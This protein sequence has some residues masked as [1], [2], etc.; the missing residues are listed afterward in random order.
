MSSLGLSLPDAILATMVSISADAVIAVDEELRIV[1]F[2]SGAERIFGWSSAEAT[3]MELA[4][5][6]PHRFRAMHSGHVTLFGTSHERARRM[7]ERQEISGLRRNGEEFAAE[8]SIARLASEGRTVYTAVLRDVSERKRIER[9][10]RA[11]LRARDDI[12]GIVSHD[13]RNPV[14]AIRML[15]GAILAS[16]D[17]RLD[18]TIAEQVTVIRHAAEQMDAL[19]QDL[20]DAARIDAGQL[21]VETRPID[22]GRLMAASVDMLEPLASAREQAL[23]LDLPADLPKVLADTARLEQV[24]SNV[25]GNAIKYTP[26]G[27]R[28]VL[29]ARDD[30]DSGDSVVVEVSDTGPGVPAEQLPHVFDRYWQSTRTGRHGAGLGLPIAKG[31]VE[32][33]G[34]RIWMES[35]GGRGTRVGFTLRR[36]Q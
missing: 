14:Q 7:G 22:V 28:I 10:L 5:L 25:V 32:A 15:S 17:E 8:A 16:S 13:L 11:A 33:H 27:G 23:V 24:L 12:A 4:E 21:H 9:D 18:P 31:I 36:A 35:E 3:G 26:R 1:F 6:L 2:N 20:L 30:G 29:S 34:G 19:I